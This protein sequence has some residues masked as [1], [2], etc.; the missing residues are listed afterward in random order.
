MKIWFRA[1]KRC[2]GDLVPDGLDRF[3][4]TLTCLQCGS[5]YTFSRVSEDTVTLRRSLVHHA[6]REAEAEPA[7]AIGGRPW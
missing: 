7:L 5:D 4:K 3:G 1:C 2:G 6:V